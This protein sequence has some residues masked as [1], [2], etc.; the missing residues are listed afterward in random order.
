[1]PRD[2]SDMNS[3]VVGCSGG[4]G[5]AI[6]HRLKGKGFNLI[7][8]D[9]KR[10]PSG[11]VSIFY[12]ADLNKTDELPGV[13]DK[14]KKEVGS[15]WSIV[16]CAGVYPIAD[17]ERYTPKLWDE[18][19]NVNVRGAFVTLMKLSPILEEG[20][21]VVTIISGAAHLGSR[22]IGYS[23]SKSALLGLT[24]SL[25]LELAP[26]LILVNAVCPGPIDT[27]MSRRMSEERVKEY[28][29]RILLRRFGRPEE[30]AVAVDFLL[31]PE[32]TFMTGA[33]LDVNGG[34]YLR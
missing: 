27:P 9:V 5:T 20:G 33:T 24:K 1:M 14:V 15:L 22:D 8:M 17:Y 26:R 10:P 23:S 28:K 32:N 16:Y 31:S 21:R 3:L 11:L 6:L 25:A 19:H 4:I 2:D 30:V 34:L 7:G 12:K 13:L 18:V 29:E